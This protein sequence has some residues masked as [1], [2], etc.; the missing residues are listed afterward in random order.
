MPIHSDDRRWAKN[1]A[2]QMAKQA[3]SDIE[4]RRWMNIFMALAKLIKID[5]YD[6][7]AWKP[8]SD[9]VPMPNI[10]DEVAKKLRRIKNGGDSGIPDGQP[11][12][13]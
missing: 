10:D 8:T 13:S 1:Y 5:I 3:Q 12:S 2:K 9:E 4:K 6:D 11:A 7:A